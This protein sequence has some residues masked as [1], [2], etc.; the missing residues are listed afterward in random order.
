M[1]KTLTL[2]KVWNKYGLS[3]GSSSTEIRL[4]WRQFNFIDYKYNS[5]VK[6]DVSALLALNLQVKHIVSA[7]I[8]LTLNAT[9]STVSCKVYN[10]LKPATSGA[11]WNTYNGTNSWSVPGGEGSGTD[12]GSELANASNFGQT[13]VEIPLSGVALMEAAVTSNG[14]F[15]LITTSPQAQNDYI[16]AWGSSNPPYLSVTYNKPSAF[17]VIIF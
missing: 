12:H 15:S 10:T 9:S 3:T 14:I 8:V 2:P 1:N 17:D 16:V 11:D 13:T 4:G 6:F 7:K 5:W